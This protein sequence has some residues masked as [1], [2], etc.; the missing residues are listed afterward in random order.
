MMR[1]T[2][3]HE[4]KING[5]SLIYHV[6]QFQRISPHLESPTQPNRTQ[7]DTWKKL[8]TRWDLRWEREVSHPNLKGR[9]SESFWLSPRPC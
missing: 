4:P 6:A 9:S 5:G 7:F 3:K 2:G 8:D 1:A